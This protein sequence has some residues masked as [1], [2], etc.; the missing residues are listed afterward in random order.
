[1]DSGESDEA[2][3]IGEELVVSGCDASELL[4]L[5]EE[6]LDTVTLLVDGAIVA[7]LMPTL[8]HG[9]DDRDGTGIED[10]V[11]Q[12]VGIIGAIGQHM[13]GVQAV[14]QG[15]GLADIAVLPGRADETHG[16]AERFDGSMELGGQAAFGATQALGIRP[17]FSLR[18][19]AAWLWAR[20]IVLSIISHSRSASWLKAARISPRTPRSIQS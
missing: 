12:P 9:R 20:I 17:P 2:H 15:F 5:V 6:A 3:E 11:V 8:R 13:L 19:P 7:M 16:V 18:A 14:D 10:G 4:E 1:M